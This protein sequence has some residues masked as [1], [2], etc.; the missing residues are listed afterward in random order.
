MRVVVQVMNDSNETKTTHE[1]LDKSDEPKESWQSEVLS[2]LYVLILGVGLAFIVTRFVFIAPLVP[3]PSMTPT[4]VPYERIFV[5]KITLFINP[6][7]RGD[8]VV[9]PSPDNPRELNVKRVVG[10]PGEIVEIYDFTILI[11][12][13]KLEEA[14]L[15]RAMSGQYDP[16]LVPDGHIFVMGDNRN[17]SMDSRYWTTTNYVALADVQGRAVAVFWP[18]GQARRLR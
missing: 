14:Y 13:T 16:F 2:F 3:T 1:A 9:F 12:G 6:V 7:A 5:D 15:D 11:N 4:I 10:M 18:L 17:N 8:I